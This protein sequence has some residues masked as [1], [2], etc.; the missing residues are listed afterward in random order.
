MI[1]PAAQASITLAEATAVNDSGDIVGYGS[2]SD[3]NTHAFL[4]TPATPGD[5]NLDGRVDINDLTVV[6]SHLNQTGCVWT[7]G[8]M[9]GDPGGTV[10]INDLTI[11]LAHYGDSLGSS[12]A[13]AAVP[14][15]ACL[16][17]FGVAAASLLL[18]AWRKRRAS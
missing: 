10:D 6:L 13:V 18:F 9:D 5:A 4:L 7:Q 1:S 3:G 14:E 2:E 17:L 16:T 12:A 11:V 15:P 8:S